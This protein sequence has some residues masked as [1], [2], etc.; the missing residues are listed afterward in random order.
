MSS[1]DAGDFRVT[2]VRAGSYHWDGGAYFGVVPK[3]LWSRYAQADELN[4][5][6][7]GFNCYVVETGGHTVLI[8]TGGGDKMDQRARERMKLE[9]GP[10]PM[11]ERIARAG[12]DPERIDIV[13][14]THLHWDHCG[15]NTIVRDGVAR[16]AFPRAAYYTRRAGW[17][18]AHERHPRDSVSY[19]DANYDPLVESGQ[20]RLI[21]EDA[22]I[23]PGIRM[24]LVPGHNRDMMLVTA[25]PFCFFSDLVPSAAHLAPTWVPAFDLFPLQSIENKTR[26]LSRAAR[27]GWI[28][29]FG[30]DCQMG[31]A[32]VE[33]QEGK[34]KACPLS[35][36]Q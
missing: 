7:L 20:M 21:E 33:E 35:P 3:T 11:P 25:G 14:N 32:R 15:G 16:A 26:W 6:P 8:E 4:R 24:H 17:E 1:V 22:E 28:C 9:A 19:I 12:I 30:H 27:E 5:V 13:L 34:F 23:V 29:G 10:D 18:H 36:A 31:F 2:L